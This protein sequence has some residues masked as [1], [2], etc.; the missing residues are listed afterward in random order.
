MKKQVIDSTTVILIFF[1]KV[2]RKSFGNDKDTCHSYRFDLSLPFLFF[3]L[4]DMWRLAPHQLQSKAQHWKLFPVFSPPVYTTDGHRELKVYRPDTKASHPKTAELQMG[5]VWQRMGSCPSSEVLMG[6]NPE[7]RT[8]RPSLC[9]EPWETSLS[10][11]GTWNSYE[12]PPGDR[13]N[14]GQKGRSWQGQVRIARGRLLTAMA[15]RPRSS[16]RP[17]LRGRSP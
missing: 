7:A 9:T 8:Q 5:A 13:R 11:L 2:R 17:R 1:F 15:R 6:E 3:L 16:A 14:P 12:W 4:K 10:D